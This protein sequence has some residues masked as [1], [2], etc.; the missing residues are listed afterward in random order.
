MASATSTTEWS[1]DN[2]LVGPGLLLHLFL[3]A[4]SVMKQGLPCPPFLELHQLQEAHGLHLPCSLAV[5][6]DHFSSRPPEVAA[7]LPDARDASPAD[8]GEEHGV[9]PEHTPVADGGNTAATT[10]SQMFVFYLLCAGSSALSER[11]CFVVLGAVTHLSAE[12]AAPDPDLTSR[13]VSTIGVNRSQTELQQ[14]RLEPRSQS[15]QA[16]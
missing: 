16:V 10:S 8:T 2:L 11:L 14:T 6:R 15:Q 7:R 4:W 13:S 12:V 1:G 5:L 9:A 3:A